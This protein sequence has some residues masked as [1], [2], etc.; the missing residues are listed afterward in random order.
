MVTQAIYIFKSFYNVC[1]MSI[2]M[3][4][5]QSECADENETK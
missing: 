3:R 5:R 2:E 1:H 4:E